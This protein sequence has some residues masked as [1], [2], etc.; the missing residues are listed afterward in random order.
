MR[1]RKMGILALAIIS[2]IILMTACGA[3]DNFNVGVIDMETLLQESQR[4][5]QLS[6]ELTEIS[7]QL[8][9]DY[10]EDGEQGDDEQ[11]IDQAYQLFLVNKEEIEEQ[12]DKEIY[13]VLGD[14]KQEKGLDIVI[15]KDSVHYGG[16]NITTEVISRLDEKYYQ[17]EEA[18][19]DQ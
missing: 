14:I 9:A 16:E 3:N 15:Y 12:L 13:D 6:Q 11:A 17:E 7:S 2:I 5:Q 18:D 19:G 10:M 1:I 8:Q 4:A